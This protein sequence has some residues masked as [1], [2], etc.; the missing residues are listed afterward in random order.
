MEYK[1]IAID[2]DNTLLDEFGNIS[3]INKKVIAKLRKMGVNFVIATGRNDILA[4]DYLEELGLYVPMI[5]CNGAVISNQFTEEIFSVNAI[6][7]DAVKRIFEYC[8]NNK[9]LFKV[10]TQDTCYTNDKVAMEKGIGQ[11]VKK[12]TRKLKY[13]IPYKFV[14]D[15]NTIS[16]MEDILKIVI[17]DDDKAERNR[18]QN[19]LQRISGV[20]V[21]FAGFNCIDIVS[22]KTAKGLA[23]AQYAEMH[24]YKPEEIIAFGDGENDISMIEYAGLG[25]AMLNGEESLKQKADLI[26]EYNN[27][28]G[29]V[30]KTLAKIYGLES[31]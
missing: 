31:V 9:L 16:D 2:C 7:K 10:L 20:N 13:T 5:S 26:T 4:R 18:I 23:L 12:Y 24:G 28:D 27:G 1:L 19:E 8:H 30:G 25:V 11:I 22:D 14:E 29:G 3:D 17:I 6:K 21:Y 15:M